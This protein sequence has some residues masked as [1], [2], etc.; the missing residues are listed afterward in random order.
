V[1]K[2][3]NL[4]PED[5]N[6]HPRMKENIEGNWVKYEDYEKL[7]S[8]YHRLKNSYETS[9]SETHENSVEWFRTHEED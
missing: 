7:L 3:Y 6:Y 8:D 5:F 2:R 9:L 1:V 4:E